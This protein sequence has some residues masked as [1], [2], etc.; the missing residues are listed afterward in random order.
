MN[1]KKKI[2][3]LT[4]HYLPGYKAG[5][6]IRSIANLVEHLGDEFEIYIKINNSGDNIYWRISST[7]R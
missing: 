3:C 2:L 6:P 5:G 1:Y 7:F 4:D